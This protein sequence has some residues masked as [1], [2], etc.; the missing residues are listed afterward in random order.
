MTSL[1]GVQNPALMPPLRTT[2]SAV[3]TAAAS[4]GAPLWKVRPSRILKVISVPSALSSQLSASIGMKFPS[5]SCVTTVSWTAGKS[6]ASHQVVLTGSSAR[7]VAVVALAEDAADNRRRASL[8]RGRGRRRCARLGGRGRRS[9]ASVVP[10]TGGEKRCRQ[11]SWRS[12]VPRRV[13]ELRAGDPALDVLIDQVL[14][15]I[16]ATRHRTPSSSRSE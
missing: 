4:Q 16:L 8:G 10:A 14:D 13:E 6:E 3:A 11:R 2:F 7:D 15:R 9:L 1:T 12:R 5:T